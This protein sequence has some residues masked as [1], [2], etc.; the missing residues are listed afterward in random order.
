MTTKSQQQE[1]THQTILES[2]A[3]LVK[4]SV[5]RGVRTLNN[6]DHQPRGW[7]SVG[8]PATAS[9]GSFLGPRGAGRSRAGTVEQSRHEPCREAL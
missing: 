7:L 1:L 5:F 6:Q 8:G 3:R 4:P 2:A 9:L